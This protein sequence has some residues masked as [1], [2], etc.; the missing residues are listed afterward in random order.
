MS[1]TNS[2]SKFRALIVDPNPLTRSYVWEAVL[3]DIHFSVVTASKSAED[4]MNQFQQ[5]FGCDVVLV[6][7]HIDILQ[8]RELMRVMKET[9]GGKEAALVAIVYANEQNSTALGSLLAEGADGLL[10]SPFSVHSLSQVAQIASRVKGDYDRKRK[11]AAA[12]I[13][14]SE[15]IAKFDDINRAL[16]SGVNSR[17]PIER[18]Q[19]VGIGLERMLE[20]S[21]GLFVEAIG[22]VIKNVEPPKSAYKG[23]SQ[24]IKKKLAA[25]AAAN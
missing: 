9:E 3:S 15:L 7:S 8:I 2:F 18:M 22:E 14:A 20:G 13:M 19:K 16:L 17:K 25:A 21:E 5:G 6:S 1:T 23:P 10:L 4:S 12:K 11:L 24:R